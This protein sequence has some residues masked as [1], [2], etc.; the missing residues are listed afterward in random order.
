M[1]GNPKARVN[2]RVQAN[3]LMQRIDGIA[4]YC[5]PLVIYPFNPA[6]AERLLRIREI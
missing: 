6:R 1:T 4:T 2:R 5:P 3:A